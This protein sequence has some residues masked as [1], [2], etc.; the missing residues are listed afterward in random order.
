MPAMFI[1]LIV[2]LPLNFFF[3]MFGGDAMPPDVVF[4]LY[5]LRCQLTVTVIIG[6][7]IGPKVRVYFL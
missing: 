5:F 6:L 4:L 7:V 3:Y 1:E 2:S